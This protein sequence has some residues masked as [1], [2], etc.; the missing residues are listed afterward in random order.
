MEHTRAE[1]APLS[2]TRHRQ[3]P[4]E[5]LASFYEVTARRPESPERR[6][7]TQRNLDLAFLPRPRERRPQI[8]LLRLE[9]I[10]P[11]G[12]VGRRQV[13][14]RLLGERQ[15]PCGMRAK[16]A[17]GLPRLLQPLK[18]KLADGLQQTKA[19]HAAGGLLAH[20]ETVVNER[21]AAPEHVA[22]LGRE[23]LR[24]SGLI[25]EPASADE[26]RK[27]AEHDLLVWVEQVVAP[28]DGMAQ[29]VVANR[30][31]AAAACQQLEPLVEARQQRARREQLHARGRQLDRERQAVEPGA[32]LRDRRRGVRRHDEIRRDRP[33]PIQKERRG[34]VRLE[35]AGVARVAG[36]GCGSGGTGYSCSPITFRGT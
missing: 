32:D 26:D 7:E 25:V 9:T 1:R 28:G 20:D 22:S 2:G 30:P 12:L 14:R 3:Q 6:A 4:L 35:D 15:E 11:R 29:A 5:P 31:I 16:G 13:G 27:A 23:H 18:G 21:L 10:E 33:R 36:S 8:G 24:D 19:R 17:L 34:R